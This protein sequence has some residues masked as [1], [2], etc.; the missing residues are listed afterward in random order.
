MAIS[1]KRLWKL[2][3]DKGMTAVELREKPKPFWDG[4]I[5]SEARPLRL[6]IRNIC[7]DETVWEVLLKK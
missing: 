4:A 7:G 1:H 6:K 5:Q 3:R 2:Y